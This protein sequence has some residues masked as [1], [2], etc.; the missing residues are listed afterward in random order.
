MLKYCDY[1]LLKYCRNNFNFTKI[2][3]LLLQ[4]I[5][6]LKAI[7]DRGIIHGDVKPE[8]LL[9]SERNG[10]FRLYVA[11]FTLANEFG[12]T[13]TYLSPEKSFKYN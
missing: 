10:D 12:G 7:A 9:V 4:A 5:S 8:N 13:P 1:D 11:D 2:R 6:G 3:D